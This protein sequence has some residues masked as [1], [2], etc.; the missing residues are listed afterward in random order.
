MNFL[1][2]SFLAAL[3]T[4]FSL[5]AQ[6]YGPIKIDLEGYLDDRNLEMVKKEEPVTEPVK[7]VEKVEPK[8]QDGPRR[9]RTAST[10]DESKTGTTDPVV[11]KK[12][13]KKVDLNRFRTKKADP[14]MMYL[15]IGGSVLLLIIIV[16]VIVI[17]KKKKAQTK[18]ALVAEATDSDVSLSEKIDAHEEAVAAETTENSQAVVSSPPVDSNYQSTAQD[19]ADQF[20]KETAVDDKGQNASGLIIDEDKYFSGSESFVDEDFSDF[21]RMLAFDILD[22]VVFPATDCLT[23]RPA[24]D[25]SVRAFE[26]RLE[27]VFPVL[28]VFCSSSGLAAM[29]ISSSSSSQP[30][31]SMS[32][33][34]STANRS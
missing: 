33:N 25:F 3:F 21:D 10:T 22:F 34:R 29:P 19:M 16:V 7:K 5:F 17:V 20:A 32:I 9:R 31:G 24:F 12:P 30:C 13:I 26:F 28:R 8:E 18:A 11:S 1:R 23:D 27:L 6:D 4:S 15:I 14:M 2:L